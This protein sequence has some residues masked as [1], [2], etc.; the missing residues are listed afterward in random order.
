M[1]GAYRSERLNDLIREDSPASGKVYDV[2]LPAT[3][4]PYRLGEKGREGDITEC[5][6]CPVPAVVPVSG[7]GVAV[8]D[9]PGWGIREQVGGT[10][11]SSSR[12][13]ASVPR[14][15]PLLRYP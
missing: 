1:S 7:T 3:D 6:D 11:F 15:R 4:C 8:D 10:H 9:N 2:S 5:G 14:L 13:W 12:V